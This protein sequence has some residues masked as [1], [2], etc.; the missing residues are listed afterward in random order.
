VRPLHVVSFLLFSCLAVNAQNS[1]P[2][3]A[4]M[5]TKIVE[6]IAPDYPEAAVSMRAEGRVAVAVNISQKGLVDSAKALYGAAIFVQPALDAAKRWRFVESKSRSERTS[7][8]AFVFLITDRPGDISVSFFPPNQ[9][10]VIALSFRQAA[11]QARAR[12]GKNDENPE[13]IKSVAP[14][15]PA[16]ALMTRASGTVTLEVRID[17]QGKVI[18][19]AAISGHP[20]LQSSSVAAARRWEFATSTSK[21][22]RSV[23]LTFIF[24]SNTAEKDAG[25]SFVSSYQVEIRPRSVVINT[26]NN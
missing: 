11:V 1:Y 22:E 10:E 20:L 19:A 9:I 24:N 6:A 7:E 3:D 8:L 25:A 14:I 2:K 15:Y 23:T 4:T 12:V 21:K 26:T 17:D 18:T 16:I 13:V 5:Q